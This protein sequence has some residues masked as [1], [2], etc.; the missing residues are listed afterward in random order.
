M[1][2]GSVGREIPPFA[3]VASEFSKRRCSG[4]RR[5]ES[6]PSVIAPPS[7]IVPFGVSPG[8][9]WQIGYRL[10]SSALY[11]WRQTSVAW[12]LL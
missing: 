8:R 5:T 4:E 12:S 2:W 3:V 10:S 7:L 9:P 1:D 6:E 11:F